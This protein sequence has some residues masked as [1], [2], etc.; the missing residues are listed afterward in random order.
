MEVNMKYIVDRVEGDLVIAIEE[1]TNK[2]IKIDKSLIDFDLF[3]GLVI[4]YE[5]GIYTKD[6]E[7]T[8]KKKKEVKNR[9][10]KLKEMN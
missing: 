10:D 4:N 8:E 9:F 1:K 3:D 7:S 5:N 6:L 2:V